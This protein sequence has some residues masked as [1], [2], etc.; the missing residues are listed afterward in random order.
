MPSAGSP[1]PIP[2]SWASGASSG[3]SRDKAD[4][5]GPRTRPSWSGGIV[6]ASVRSTST[7]GANGR[8]SAPGSTHCPDS[9]PN[10]ASSARADSSRSSRVLPT[11]ASPPRSTNPVSPASARSSAAAK[12]ASS[13]PRPINTGL[14]TSPLM[15]KSCH[16][17]GALAS[18]RDTAKRPDPGGHGGFLKRSA[19]NLNTGAMPDKAPGRCADRPFS[20]TVELTP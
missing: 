6:R 13:S 17:Y 3:S 7:S 20:P 5:A 8:P 12:T 10:P 9:T 4:A 16:K 2:G 11:P 18:S 15:D 1:R 14:T 19:G